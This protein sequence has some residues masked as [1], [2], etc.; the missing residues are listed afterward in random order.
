LN[1]K[2]NSAAEVDSTTA[3]ALEEDF[4]NLVESQLADRNVSEL[5]PN[6]T[7]LV[8][9]L[10]FSHKTLFFHSCASFFFFLLHK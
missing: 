10:F 5:C 9:K 1:I 2:V 3:T 8:R 7:V 6:T 4:A